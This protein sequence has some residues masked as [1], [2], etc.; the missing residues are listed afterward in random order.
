MTLKKVINRILLFTL[1]IV[2]LL[3]AVNVVLFVEFDNVK[4]A[5]FYEGSDKAWSHRGDNRMTGGN[6]IAST[7]SAL[8][9]GYSGIEVDV[10]FDTER[11]KLLASHE[12]RFDKKTEALVDFFQ[13]FPNE[14]F[15]IDL[16]N[17]NKN[18]YDVILNEL[19]SLQKLIP[20]LL[21]NQ[22][23]VFPWAHSIKKD[24]ILVYG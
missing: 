12:Y 2:L 4:Q 16:K 14:Y 13:Q 11:N 15:W 24:L 10:W 18:H 23:I 22:K 9:N 7:Q 20:I 3:V 8:K 19:N 21:L 1:G 17:L 5:I 6:T